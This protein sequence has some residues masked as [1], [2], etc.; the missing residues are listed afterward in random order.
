MLYTIE[1][2][3]LRVTLKSFG[4]EP[5]SIYGKAT[6]CE[7]LW[8]GDAAYWAGQAPVLFPICGRLL[9]G[10]YTYEG[11]RYEMNLHGFARKME[12]AV[13][14]KTDTSIT[15]R[16]TDNEES[17]RQYPFSFVYRVRYTL[18]GDTLEVAYSVENTD[19][20]TLIF[21]FGAHPGFNVPLGNDKFTDYKI[22]FF[23]F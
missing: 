7:Y 18:S 4:G 16:L 9:D 8:Q 21:A 10:Y 13:E 3:R 19:E 5:I 1:N 11:K 22:V 14:E 17:R 15:F 23:L 6:A 20:K 2:E 12:M